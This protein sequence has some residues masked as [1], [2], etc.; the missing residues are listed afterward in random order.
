MSNIS[1]LNTRNL[2]PEQQR[3]VNMYVNQYNQTNSHIDFLL[4]MLDEIRAEAFKSKLSTHKNHSN[5]MRFNDTINSKPITHIEPG[6]KVDMRSILNK[7]DEMKKKI[8][9]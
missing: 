3:L 8:N 6:V 9:H 4:D 5:A 7:I 2:T 1:N